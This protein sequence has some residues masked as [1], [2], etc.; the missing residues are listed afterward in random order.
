VTKGETV[1]TND[2]AKYPGSIGSEVKLTSER[3]AHFAVCLLL[4]GLPPGHFHMESF[5]G[6]PVFCGRDVI[7]EL[8]L[9]NMKGGF[10]EAHRPVLEKLCAWLSPLLSMFID[11]PLHPSD[12]AAAA[13]EA[14]TPASTTEKPVVGGPAAATTAKAE[15]KSAAGATTVDAA[16]AA[17]VLPAAQSADAISPRDPENLEL[18]ST[19]VLS[20]VMQTINEGLI[21]LN[22]DLKVTASMLPLTLPRQLMLAAACL[23]DSA[24]R[25]CSSTTERC[26][27][28]AFTSRRRRMDSLW[29]DILPDSAS[30][31]RAPAELVLFGACCCC[32]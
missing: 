11:L 18:N 27:F 8:G 29:Y 16:A 30:L 12:V 20:A 25:S 26:A 22:T 32:C 21:L 10:T 9:A 1:M 7:G 31:P 19:E 28:W 14:G 2:P 17:S 13:K 3:R 5:A 15:S 4:S 23:A 24:A 6:F